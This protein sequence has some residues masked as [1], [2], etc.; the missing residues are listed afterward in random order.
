[1][2]AKQKIFSI[3]IILLIGSMCTKITF[4]QTLLYKITTSNK[5]FN[6]KTVIT[7]LDNGYLI[8]T[9]N[10]LNKDESTYSTD[11]SFSII[12]WNFHSS[13]KGANIFAK[14]MD[15]IIFVTGQIKDKQI[16][17]KIEIDNLPW[18]QEWGWGLRAHIISNKEPIRFWT[19]NS[20][21]QQIAKFEAKKEKPE[22]IE[23]NGQKIES[24]YVKIRLTGV[25]K[26][27]WSGDMWFRKSDGV[28][29]YSKMK[30]GSTGPITIMQLIN[31]RSL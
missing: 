23:L 6:R 26:L 20:N 13:E 30:D 22:T 9:S 2:T 11:L 29:L 8:K 28:F 31:E 17:E 1:M 5:E 24:V 19:L 3:L 15:N 27:L 16:N 21:F 18:Y 12:Q 4:A 25:M 10:L 7:K 14:R